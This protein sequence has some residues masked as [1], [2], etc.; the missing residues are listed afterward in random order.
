M[1]GIL[2]SIFKNLIFPNRAKGGDDARKCEFWL[3]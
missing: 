3:P 2:P 1:G